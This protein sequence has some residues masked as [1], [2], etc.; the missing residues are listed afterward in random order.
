MAIAS[1]DELYKHCHGDADQSS[2]PLLIYY[3]K[4]I[5]ATGMILSIVDVVR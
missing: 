2:D 3:H 5:I 4:V 1:D